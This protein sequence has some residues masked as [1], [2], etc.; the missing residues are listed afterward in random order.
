MTADSA[1]GYPVFKKYV[2]AMGLPVARTKIISGAA[3][4]RL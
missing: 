2:T 3:L 1:A 4:I